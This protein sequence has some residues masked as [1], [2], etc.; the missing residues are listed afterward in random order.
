[1]HHI[2]AVWNFPFSKRKHMISR[3][4]NIAWEQ[5]FLFIPFQNHKINLK[6]IYGSKCC[7]KLVNILINGQIESLLCTK[8]VIQAKNVR[9][10]LI[11]SNNNKSWLSA[12]VINN[13]DDTDGPVKMQSLARM[14]LARG[15][16]TG[17]SLGIIWTC[18]N[19]KQ[20]SGQNI[21]SDRILMQGTKFPFLDLY[22]NALVSLRL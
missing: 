21:V 3:T 11:L 2:F 5:L 8:Y 22:S 7:P 1:M 9:I 4:Y 18:R 10:K 12:S 19:F 20:L 15:Q 13:N 16:S 17:S 6:F 14:S